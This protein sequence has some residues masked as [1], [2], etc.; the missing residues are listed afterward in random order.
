M[1]HAI[2]HGWT[3]ARPTQGDVDCHEMWE[4]TQT[5]S[6]QVSLTTLVLAQVFRWISNRATV[7]LT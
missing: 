4:D 2:L 5:I 1:M 6:L 3:L 7:V